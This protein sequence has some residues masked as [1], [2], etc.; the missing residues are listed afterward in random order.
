MTPDS[1]HINMSVIDAPFLDFPTLLQ[2]SEIPEEHRKFILSELSGSY[3]FVSV[4]I[5]NASG[6]LE[7]TI[8]EFL[9]DEWTNPKEKTSGRSPHGTKTTYQMVSKE[10]VS[11]I[12]SNYGG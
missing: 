12:S 7:L 11:G 9:Y 2:S 8:D 4:S 10:W 5:S 3:P 1:T 6:T